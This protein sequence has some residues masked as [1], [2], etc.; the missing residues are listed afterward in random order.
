MKLGFQQRIL[1]IFKTL[2]PWFYEIPI[3]VYHSIGGDKRES[4]PLAL[5]KKHLQFFK[6]NGFQVISLYRLIELMKEK[7][8]TSPSFISLTFD[9]GYADCFY[10]AYPLLKEYGFPATIFVV[11]DKIGQKGYL[12]FAQLKQMPNDKLVTIGSHTMNHRDLLS[13]DEKG[14]FY[15]IKESKRV[16][17][18]NLNCKIDLFSYPWG[19]YSPH[20]QEILREVGYQA[21]FSTNLKVNNGLHSKDLYALRRL[22]L[23]PQ[24]SYLRFLVKISGF[25]TFFARS[26]DEKN[27]I[28]N[29]ARGIKKNCKLH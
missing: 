11:V 13:L 16:L 5:F 1:G 8:I 26:I 24:D 23:D 20:I 4:L 19:R 21:A 2:F 10:L 27:R 28:E 6:E 29:G 3:L 12:D 9:D 22:T 18:C 25:G 15:E 14:L 7:K 17:E